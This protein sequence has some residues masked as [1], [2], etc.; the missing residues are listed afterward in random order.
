MGIPD[1]HDAPQERSDAARQPA[2]VP[3]AE[4][5]T[6][7]AKRLRTLEGKAMLAAFIGESWRVMTL[8]WQCLRS[9]LLLVRPE[10][11]LEA[12]PAFVEHLGRSREKTRPKQIAVFQ[13][14]LSAPRQISA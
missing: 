12:L 1:T 9:G 3:A 13:A 7:R 2:L 8:V 5:P 11:L 10:K 4:P 6:G 14:E